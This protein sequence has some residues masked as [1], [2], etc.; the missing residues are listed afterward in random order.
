MEFNTQTIV[1]MV[2]NIFIIA[3][4]FSLVLSLVAK[5]TNFFMSFVLGRR[6]ISL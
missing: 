6:E 5:I 4:P 3:F 1:D 2:S